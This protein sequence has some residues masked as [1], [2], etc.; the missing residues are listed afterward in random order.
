MKKW[1]FQILNDFWFQFLLEVKHII[2]VKFKHIPNLEGLK[3]KD[4]Q[5]LQPDFVQVLYCGNLDFNKP[6]ILESLPFSLDLSN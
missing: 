1:S 3:I 2:M 6:M 4:F 5:N